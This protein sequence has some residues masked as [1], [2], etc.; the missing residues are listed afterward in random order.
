MKS[1][2]LDAADNEMDGCIHILK[3]SYMKTSAQE[4]IRKLSQSTSLLANFA[5]KDI[6]N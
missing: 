3:D 4:F 2:S 1:L 6:L 5:F